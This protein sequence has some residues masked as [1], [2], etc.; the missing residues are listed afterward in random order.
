MKKPIH[1][2]VTL[3]FLLIS[4]LAADAQPEFKPIFNGKDLWMGWQS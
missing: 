2:F 4:V 1:S 3:P